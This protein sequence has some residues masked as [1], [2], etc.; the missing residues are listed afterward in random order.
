LPISLLALSSSALAAPTAPSASA[1]AA[2]ASAAPSDTRVS[3]TCSEHLPEGKARPK[4]EE[5]ISSHGISGHAHLLKVTIEHG[6]GET[7][8]PSGFRLEPATD[9]YKALESSHF[10]LPDPKGDAKPRVERKDAAGHSTTTVKLWFVPLP[11]KP[12]RS[13]LTLP[14]LPIAISRASGEI[15]TLCTNAH[16]VSI[17][18]P[19]AN[20]PNPMPRANP[21]PR[22]QREEWTTAKQVTYAALIAL[23]VGAVLATLFGVWRRRP[24]K[25]PPPVPPRPPWEVAIEGLYDT[26][27]SGLLGEQRYAEFYDRVSDIV[28]RYLGDR[29]GYDGLESTTREALGQLR[30]VSIPLEVLLQIQEFMQDSDLVKFA[31]RAPTEAECASAIERAEAIVSRTRPAEAPSLVAAP[32]PAP[33]GAA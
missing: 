10:F 30:R 9:E 13:Q 6:P 14:P 31:R 22:I 5:T 26:R 3:S 21:A 25:L 16:T 11:E 12:G 8:L 2:S 32:E 20:E 19:I 17:E 1:P 27:H 23:V 29:Y 28:R 4:L 24:K 7:V 33:G 18:D 15:I